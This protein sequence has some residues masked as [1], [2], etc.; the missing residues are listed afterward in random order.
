M[1]DF[2]FMPSTLPGL[3]LKKGY[4]HRVGDFYDVRNTFNKGNSYIQGCNPSTGAMITLVKDDDTSAN[5]TPIGS[6]LPDWLYLKDL[7]TDLRMFY[8]EC[9]KNSGGVYEVKEAIEW[10][11][12]H[13]K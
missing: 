5:P 4:I 12:C 7:H 8:L 6:D 1:Y 9:V 2:G 13:V 10:G 11:Q 3:A